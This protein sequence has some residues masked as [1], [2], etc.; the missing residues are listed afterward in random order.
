[1]RQP[2]G[3]PILRGLCAPAGSAGDG[4]EGRPAG[5]L[6]GHPLSFYW[7]HPESGTRFAA[8]GE[9][10]RWE[11]RTARELRDVFSALTAPRA[12]SFRAHTRGRITSHR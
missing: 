2:D 12:A 4:A 8:Y 10:A 1:M 9:A 6:A 3:V 11:A 7:A 5:A